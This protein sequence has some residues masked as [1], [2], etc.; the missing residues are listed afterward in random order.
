MKN[1]PDTA[2]KKVFVDHY[3]FS[4]KDNYTGEKA[5]LNLKASQFNAYATKAASNIEDFKIDILQ[6]E[7]V[8]PIYSN[9][10]IVKYEIDLKKFRIPREQ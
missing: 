2:D 1:G 3:D 6:Q 10:K 5:E 9:G 8:T 4:K 7:G